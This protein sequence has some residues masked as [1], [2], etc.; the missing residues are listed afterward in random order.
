M[1]CNMEDCNIYENVEFPK[2]AEKK[3]H[4]EK[5]DQTP[6]GECQDADSNIDYECFEWEDTCHT[7]QQNQKQ[8]QRGSLELKS[9]RS[10]GS[11]GCET[12]Y[13]VLCLVLATVF[14]FFMSLLMAVF[15]SNAALKEE[16]KNLRRT[17]SMWTENITEAMRKLTEEQDS[18]S[19]QDAN[20]SS[21]IAQ[22]RMQDASIFAEITQLKL[23]VYALKSCPCDWKMF[24][25][26]CYY[27]SQ[28][29]R[30]WNGAKSHCSQQG[31]NLAVVKTSEELKFLG[32][33]I[34]SDHWLGLI[35][36]QRTWT[37]LDGSSVER[38]FWDSGRPSSNPG[39]GKMTNKLSKSNC[40]S[41]YRWIC[42][43]A[44]LGSQLCV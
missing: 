11:A 44:A 5:E 43:K 35:Y 28:D 34:S 3:Q 33:Q 42:E 29:T 8:P 21:Q 36:Q 17:H 13:T 20:I 19:T 4:G 30:D 38:S 31:S 7:E 2:D 40:A 10:T 9:S 12:K 18:L 24:N 37:W 26:K 39:C 25:G 23:H 41:A 15:I 27:F 6:S 16:I 1:T 32:S 14:V 22:L